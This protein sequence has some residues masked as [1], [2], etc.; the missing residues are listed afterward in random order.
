MVHYAGENTPKTL[1]FYA[2]RINMGH[3]HEGWFVV[4][5]DRNGHVIEPIMTVN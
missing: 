4:E 3:M 5:Y 1:H 2:N